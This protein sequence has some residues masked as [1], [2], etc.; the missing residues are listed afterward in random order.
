ME[1][2][3]RARDATARALTADRLG[4]PLPPDRFGEGAT[5]ASFAET[6][7]FD[8]VA[9]TWDIT[10]PHGIVLEVSD[11]HITRISR[12]AKRVVTRRP[13]LFASEVTAPDD[14]DPLTRLMLF[15]GRSDATR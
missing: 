13:G 6:L 11:E 4:T 14:A 2:W 8:L 10:H 5:L 3:L 7:E 1:T 15:C 9:H 12:T